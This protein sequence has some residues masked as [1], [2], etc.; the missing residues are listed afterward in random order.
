V[1][2]KQKVRQWLTLCK[3]SESLE[4]PITGVSFVSTIKVNVDL[5]FGSQE[6]NAAAALLQ[7]QVI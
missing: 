1:G 6:K 5:C 3:I 2:N 7:H 4:N